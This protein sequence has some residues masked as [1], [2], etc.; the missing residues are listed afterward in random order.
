MVLYSKLTIPSES[1]FIFFDQSYVSIHFVFRDGC[2][3]SHG[4]LSRV[5]LIW[6]V[7]Q[8]EGRAFSAPRK[9][10]K[11]RKVSSAWTNQKKGTPFRLTSQKKHSLWSDQLE[12]GAT[13]GGQM[14]KR[15][16]LGGNQLE[17][18]LPSLGWCPGYWLDKWS[19]VCILVL[20]YTPWVSCL[21][22]CNVW[23]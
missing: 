15:Q 20:N 16:P 9:P 12:K 5:S 3:W 18:V 10:E 23:N 1:E 13:S 19:P 17:D 21:W 2:P 6:C 8:Q 11:K 14:R 4:H 22:T 7:Y